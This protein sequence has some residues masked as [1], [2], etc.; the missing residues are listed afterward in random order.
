MSNKSI[1][2]APKGYNGESSTELRKKAQDLLFQLGQ[3][4]YNKEFSRR[5]EVELNFGLEDLEEKIAYAVKSEQA[6]KTEVK[7]PEAPT[8]VA[9]DQAVSNPG[10]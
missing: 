3:A 1:S 4:S 6:A 7:L 2:G 9:S 8:E 5:Q 10:A